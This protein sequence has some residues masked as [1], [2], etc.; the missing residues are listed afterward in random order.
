[1]HSSLVGLPV[2]L[3]SVGLSVQLGSVCMAV[4]GFSC[5]YVTVSGKRVHSAQNVLSSYKRL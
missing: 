5:V 2:Q 4:L 1:M 3:G